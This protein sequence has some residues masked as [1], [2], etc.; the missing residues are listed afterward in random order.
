MQCM[1]TD[2]VFEINGVEYNHDSAYF[3]SVDEFE[4]VRSAE[5]GQICVH[6][7]TLVPCTQ[8][9]PRERERERERACVCLLC[10]CHVPHNHT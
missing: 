3:A 2:V 10:M 4:K 6:H 9:T 8:Q 7:K 5:E 1:L